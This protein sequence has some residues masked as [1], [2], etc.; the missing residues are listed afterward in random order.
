MPRPLPLLLLALITLSTQA[1]DSPATGT[2]EWTYNT[3]DPKDP[4]I[5]VIAKVSIKLIQDGQSLTGAFIER[6]G[7]EVPIADGQITPAGQLSFSV[8]RDINGEK[9]L[10]KYRGQLTANTITG[11][12]DFHKGEKIT[13]HD[14]E[15]TRALAKK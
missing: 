7:K 11:K 3:K 4:K 6:S 10:F 2:W 5:A 13:P 12:I 15:A 1:A 8:T 14:W 9:R